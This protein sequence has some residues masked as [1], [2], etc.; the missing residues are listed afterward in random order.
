[1]ALL[2]IPIG[3]F[4]LRHP[5]L[6]L[7]GPAVIL[8]ACGDLFLPIRYRLGAKGVTSTCGFVVS[9]IEWTSVKS[10]RFQ[11]DGVVVSPLEREGRMEAFRGVYLRYDG[12]EAA[13]LAKIGEFWNEHEGVLGTGTDGGANPA[14]DR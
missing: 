11:K 1:M 2:T 7:L 13:V 3:W 10:L 4:L 8:V 5:L 9:E 12:N 14:D 6:A